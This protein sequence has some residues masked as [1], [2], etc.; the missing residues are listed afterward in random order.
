MRTLVLLFCLPLA[1]FAQSESR[2]M[3]GH[4]GSRPALMV[5]HASKNAEGAWQLAGE[6]I[7]L[8][9]LQRRFL[10]GESSPEIGVTTL[11][12]GET[13]IVFGRA[14]TGELR[15]TLREGVFKGARYAPGG[16]ERERFEFSEEFP[17]MESYSAN[18]RCEVTGGPYRSTFNMRVDA[19]KLQAFEW[20]STLAGSGQ[21]CNIDNLQQQPMKG[22]LRFASGKCSVTLREIGDYV[23]LASENCT[24][25]CGSQAYVEPLFIDR[26]GNCQLLRGD[27][28]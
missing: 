26:R 5:L 23:R 25:L 22:G 2:E 24:E 8:P 18:V 21:A 6:Y 16:Q 13:A 15:G 17:A 3:G 9:T 10:E 14:T 1:A 12:E 7:V 27:S 19:G 4:L 28:R 11:R 20:R